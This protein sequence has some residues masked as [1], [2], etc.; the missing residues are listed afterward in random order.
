MG[1][2]ICAWCGKRLGNDPRIEGVSHG[3]C[4]KCK[5]RELVKWQPG[6]AA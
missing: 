3:I 6:R 2:I 5:E 1:L 4:P